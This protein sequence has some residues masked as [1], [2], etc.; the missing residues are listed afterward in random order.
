MPAAPP[1]AEA[2]KNVAAIV[3]SMLTPSSAAAMRSCATARMLRP[4]R[5]R[6]QHVAEDEHQADRRRRR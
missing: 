3:R 2:M 5:R 1:S 4:E 6:A